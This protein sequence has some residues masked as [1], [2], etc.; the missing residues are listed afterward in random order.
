MSKTLYVYVFHAQLCNVKLKILTDL[1][2]FVKMQ[3]E[4]EIKRG[5][6]AKLKI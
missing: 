5:S 1:A 4:V 2:I 3:I 6:T